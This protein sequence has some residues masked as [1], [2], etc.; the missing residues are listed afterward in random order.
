GPPP[1]WRARSETSAGSAPGIRPPDSVRSTSS[2][3]P[4]PRRTSAWAPS[5][6][7]CS[8][9]APRRSRPPSR[10]AP[11][12]TARESSCTSRS[13]RLPPSSSAV[14]GRASS[15]TPQL[16]SY[17]TPPAES[18]RSCGRLASV[19]RP[20]VVSHLLDQVR[21]PPAPRHQLPAHHASPDAHA[22]RLQRDK[23]VLL[24]QEDQLLKPGVKQRARIAALDLQLARDGL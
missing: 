12:G 13:R 10:P 8:S 6:S 2:G 7:T 1:R 22:A 20:P 18:T 9:E 14:S 11:A 23:E 21:R 4:S 24:S 16:M 17:P 5:A 19:E 3:T 15:R